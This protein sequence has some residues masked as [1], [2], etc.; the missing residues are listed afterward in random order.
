MTEKDQHL[1]NEL[2]QNIR[3]LIDGLEQCKDELEQLRDEKK[4]LELRLASYET[5]YEAL[6]KRYENLKVAKVLAEGDPDHQAAKL[7]INKIIREVD[8]CIA[9]LNQ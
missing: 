2:K 9:L 6:N 1:I 3:R 5:E 7:K 8:K 4:G